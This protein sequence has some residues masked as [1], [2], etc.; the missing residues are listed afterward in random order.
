MG[1][2]FGL[3]GEKKNPADKQFM[4]E[5]TQWDGQSID[6]KIWECLV[7]T[8]FSKSCSDALESEELYIYI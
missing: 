3:N 5:Y 6:K 2:L 7:G 8:G 1:L 4:A